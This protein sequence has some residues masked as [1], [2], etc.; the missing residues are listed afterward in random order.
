M[1]RS[2]G[3]VLEKIPIAEIN[4]SI[5]SS[6]VTTSAKFNE[7]K[8]NQINIELRNTEFTMNI[9]DGKF[10]MEKAGTEIKFGEPGKEKSYGEYIKERYKAN[11]SVVREGKSPEVV[12][13]S[14]RDQA[15][16]TATEMA[17]SMYGENPNQRIVDSFSDR[18]EL[19]MNV[20]IKVFELRN[21]RSGLV[22]LS[23]NVIAE[24]T[25]PTRNRSGGIDNGKPPE[26]AKAAADEVLTANDKIESLKKKNPEPKELEKAADKVFDEKLKEAKTPEEK[27]KVEEERSSWK[28]KLKWGLGIGLAGFF[29]Y[30]A[31]SAH[32]ASRSGC[33]VIITDQ[34]TGTTTTCKLPILTCDN[35]AA[36][37]GTTCSFSLDNGWC[38]PPSTGGTSL[39]P[40][41][42]SA[43]TD[44]FSQAC[45]NSCKDSV[46]SKYCNSTYMVKS[47]NG[48]N[49]DYICVDCDIKCALND[50]ANKVTDI[51]GKVADTFG[52]VWDLLNN[53]FKYGMYFIIGFIVLYCL[54]WLITKF[55]GG[56]TKQAGEEHIVIEQGGGG[57]QGG[58]EQ[59]GIEQGGQQGGGQQVE[60]SAPAPVPILGERAA[61][62]PLPRP[63]GGSAPVGVNIPL[64]QVPSDSA[65]SAPP[66]PLITQ[67]LSSPVSNLFNLRFG[68]GRKGK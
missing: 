10:I 54:Y 46:C 62:A 7:A 21:P 32:A 25:N 9:R 16:L 30:E 23:P 39:S 34:L 12:E 38:L 33:F 41:G 31:L 29:T 47:A 6:D 51:L 40:D 19:D 37:A 22:E 68:K 43:C 67:S 50:T 55:V 11:E 64:I 24:A 13:K 36:T 15:R 56:D 27:A 4:R 17:K 8:L 53:I 42:C 57:G 3:V 1:S 45:S 49:Y 60:W 59:G 65:P 26:P 35:E 2:R 5:L 18:I 44:G 61:S 14:V 58:I 28:E 63:R 48:K 20:E 52:S 66:A